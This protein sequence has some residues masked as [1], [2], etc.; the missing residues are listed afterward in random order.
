MHACV[1]LKQNNNSWLSTT[2]KK[3]P[4]SGL[5]RIM[6]WV[7]WTL[8][9]QCTYLLFVGA[10]C[11]RIWLNWGVFLLDEVP[12]LATKHSK[13]V[14]PGWLELDWAARLGQGGWGLGF[15]AWPTHWT[16]IGLR[17]PT[18][19]FT[20]KIKQGPILKHSGDSRQLCAFKRHYLNARTKANGNVCRF[21]FYDL[22][23]FYA[24]QYRP[25]PR[26]THKCDFTSQITKLVNYSGMSHSFKS[27][28][29]VMC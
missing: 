19:N 16:Q 11:N 26:G 25:S 6:L 29:N 14:W 1:Q 2:G 13:S 20:I 10:A 7:C 8:N 9:R 15:R 17:W 3:I 28:S 12:H 24:Q 4:L 22:S 21:C 5:I 18:C 23:T 27:V